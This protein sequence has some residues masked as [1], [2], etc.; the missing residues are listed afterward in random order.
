VLSI[1]LAIRHLSRAKSTDAQI[2]AWESEVLNDELG[3]ANNLVLILNAMKSEGGT[4]TGMAAML[5][6]HKLMR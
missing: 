1:V 4:E 2:A 3:G 5:S 6:L